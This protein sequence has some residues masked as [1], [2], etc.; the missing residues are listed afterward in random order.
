MEAASSSQSKRRRIL[1]ARISE[2]YSRNLQDFDTLQNNRQKRSDK[3][4]LDVKFYSR[5]VGSIA[6]PLDSSIDE[7]N[8]YD[9][10]YA[11]PRTLRSWR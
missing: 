5:L 8:L 9:R 10:K 2:E 6:E 1:P 11:R 4:A 3:N 7:T